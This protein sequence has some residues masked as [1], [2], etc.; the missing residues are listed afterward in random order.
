M[1]LSVWALT[2]SV[3]FLLSEEAK[4]IKIGHSVSPEFRLDEYQKYSPFKLRLLGAIK[5]GLPKEREL[6]RRFAHLRM[7]GEWFRAEPELVEFVEAL[8]PKKTEAA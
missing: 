1:A 8:L 7:R 3:Y 2:T 5:G 4:A 6:H